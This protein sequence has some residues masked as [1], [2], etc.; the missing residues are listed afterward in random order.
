MIDAFVH[1]LYHNLFNER[2]Y[3]IELIILY[4]LAGI[5]A[6]LTRLIVRNKEKADFNKWLDDGSLIGAILISVVGSVLVDNDF[7]W[8][9]IGGYFITY[10]LQ[11]LQGGLDKIIG[12]RKDK[13][14]R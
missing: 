6:G 8:S 1:N 4:V 13:N 7:V 9:F 12:N 2:T 11:F 3:T 5:L 10:I 14:E